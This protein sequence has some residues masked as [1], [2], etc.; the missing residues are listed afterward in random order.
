MV[1]AQARLDIRE[2]GLETP[3]VAALLHAHLS[4]LSRLSR[5]ES[6]HALDADALRAAD[7]SFWSAWQ[8]GTLAGIGALKRLDATH[9]EIKSMRTADA[10]LRTGVAARLVQH[11]VTQARRRGWRRLSLETGASAAFA[12]AHR[13]YLKCGFVPCGPFGD[14][15]EDSESMFLC[16]HLPAA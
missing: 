16:R 4:G 10:F 14:Y 9:G 11:L 7:V 15:V 6:M 8:D 1:T 12:P 3:A 13:L 5:P 2:G